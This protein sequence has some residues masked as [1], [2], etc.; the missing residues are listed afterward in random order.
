MGA[1]GSIQ[2]VSIKGSG[3][4]WAP[5][6]RNWGANWQSDFYLNG[7]SLS[8]R[9]TTDD[10]EVRVFQD[11]VPSNWAFGDILEPT[12]VLKLIAKCNFKR[13][14]FVGFSGNSVLIIL[15]KATRQLFGFTLF[16]VK[17]E[18]KC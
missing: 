12:S 1:A 14:G 11:I 13:S 8:F 10:G 2:S 5:M 4:D 17:E 18:E 16:G 7:Q 3:T 9:V 6:S 15:L